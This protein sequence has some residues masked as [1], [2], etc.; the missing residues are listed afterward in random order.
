MDTR[1]KPTL[2]WINLQ[3]NRIKLWGNTNRIW[4]CFFWRLLISSWRKTFFFVFFSYYFDNLFTKMW[5]EKCVF[6]E[7]K[8]NKINKIKEIILWWNL[9]DFFKVNRKTTNLFFHFFNLIMFVLQYFGIPV[10]S[11]SILSK[12]IST[13]KIH[14]IFTKKKTNTNKYINLN[15]QYKIKNNKNYFNVSWSL[16]F[17]FLVIA[18][19]LC[20]II[21][22]KIIIKIEYKKKEEKEINKNR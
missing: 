11:N 17:F 19:A 7:K 16:I 21:F 2:N 5:L 8:S 22:G 3:E 20:Q 10:C 9:H 4:V 6:V 15:A 12:F 1:P 18:F 13:T 14:C